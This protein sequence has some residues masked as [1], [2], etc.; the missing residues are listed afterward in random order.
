M[1]PMTFV[2]FSQMRHS[3]FMLDFINGVRQILQLEI[4][5]QYSMTL[6]RFLMKFLASLRCAESEEG[7]HCIIDGVVNFLIGH[8]SAKGAVR[9]NVCKFIDMLTKSLSEDVEMLDEVHTKLT[10][11]LEMHMHDTVINVRAQAAYALCRFQNPDDKND[12][13]LCIYEYHLSH[14][15]AVSVRQ[16]ILSSIARNAITVPFIIERFSDIDEKV[17][18]SAYLQMSSYPVRHLK[19]TQ[20]QQ[21]VKLG[22]NDHSEAV[23][24]VVRD[25]LLPRWFQS[26]DKQY[27]NFLSALKLDD[28]YEE[29]QNFATFSK[30]TLIDQFK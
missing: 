27:L 5:N 20:R 8:T 15:P 23:C 7:F 13:V 25:V 17:R 14:D 21:F 16:A 30:N 19:L 11:C 24:K 4:L 2:L 9:A 12:K 10:D 28:N 1:K 26:Y 18:R 29:I 6:L 3:D 22:L